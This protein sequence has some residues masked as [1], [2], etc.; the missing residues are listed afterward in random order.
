MK[1][2]SILKGWGRGIL[3]DHS[4][5]IPLLNQSGLLPQRRAC[6]YWSWEL[7]QSTASGPQVY[8]ALESDIQMQTGRHNTTETHTPHF[9]KCVIHWLLCQYLRWVLQGHHSP[10]ILS[11]TKDPCF[12]WRQ[13]S[14]QSARSQTFRLLNFAL[15]SEKLMSW[16]PPAFF[17]T[18]NIH[19]G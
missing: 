5:T 8:L 14:S 6:C 4:Q 7:S 18:L 9:V 16:R 11:Y 3:T 13:S 10:A 12:S 2:I 15:W 1:G 17:P 19:C